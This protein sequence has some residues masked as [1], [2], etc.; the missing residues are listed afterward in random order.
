MNG[1]N[2]LNRPRHCKR[3][4]VWNGAQRWNGWN[5]WSG[6][7]LMLEHEH[8]TAGFS[9]DDHVFSVFILY[10]FSFYPVGITTTALVSSRSRP[11]YDPSSFKIPLAPYRLYPLISAYSMEGLLGKYHQHTSRS[12]LDH[13]SDRERS[14]RGKKRLRLVKTLRFI[15]SASRKTATFL[16]IRTT[17]PLSALSM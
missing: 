1:L 9:D 17:K 8:D 3:L 2:D 4:N 11:L 16:L 6:S 7:Y 14:G 10:P 15:M 13:A 12:L 5:H